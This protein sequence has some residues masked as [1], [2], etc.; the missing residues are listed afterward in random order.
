MPR[1]AIGLLFGLCVA[2][3]YANPP[4]WQPS[5]GNKQLPIWPSAVPDAVAGPGPESVETDPK[6]ASGGPITWVTNVTHPTIT[7]YT[8]DAKNNSGVAIVVIP[9]GGFEGLAMDL[10]GT[11]ICDW[12]VSRGIAAVLVKYRV[13]SV[14]YDWHCDCRPDNLI[15]PTPALEDLQ[16]TIGFVRSRASEWHVNPQKIG[17]IGFSA[18]GYLVAAISTHFDHRLYAPVD[19]ADKTSCRPDFAIAIYPGHLAKDRGKSLGLNPNVPATAKTPPTFLLQSEDDHVDSVNDSLAYYIGL[20]KAGVPAEIHLYAEGGH[21]FGLRPSSL[22][23]SRWP[24]LV[25][26]WLKTIRMTGP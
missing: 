15:V 25:E 20:K 2:V 13:P 21:G 7:L 18:G 5:S 8:P 19:E 14:P 4:V 22:P 23:V 16:R 12:L 1:I 9:G 11:E 6:G 3:V 24:A 26:T 17:V 10:E